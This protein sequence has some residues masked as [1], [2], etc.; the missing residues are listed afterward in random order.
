MLVLN[1]CIDKDLRSEIKRLLNK[2]TDII[3]IEDSLFGITHSEVGGR[4]L[5]KWELSE[6]F[7]HSI[8]THHLPVINIINEKNLLSKIIYPADTIASEL[9]RPVSKVRPYLNIMQSEEAFINVLPFKTREEL[10]DFYEKELI[11]TFDDNYI[12]YD[13]TLFMN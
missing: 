2:G 6:S 7:I 12:Q 10:N 13:K 11:P 8:I 1:H 9:L 3:K 5:K 4:L